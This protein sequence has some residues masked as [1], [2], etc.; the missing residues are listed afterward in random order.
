[1]ILIHQRHRQTD[2]QRDGW[3]AISITRYALVHRAVKIQDICGKWHW[4]QTSLVAG[5]ECSG[6]G[7]NV[8]FGTTFHDAV[9]VV[10]VLLRCHRPTLSV[11][12]Y[13]CLYVC[14]FVCLDWSRGSI[15]HVTE[16]YRVLVNRRRTWTW[17]MRSHWPVYIVASTT[18]LSRSQLNSSLLKHGIAGWLKEIQQI[19]TNKTIKVSEVKTIK[20]TMITVQ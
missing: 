9:T 19:K 15:R 13:V 14:V 16:N 20:Q 18:E 1:V 12:L 3:H 7:R 10:G 5:V 6:M 8:H 11:C 17:L 4:K 2:R